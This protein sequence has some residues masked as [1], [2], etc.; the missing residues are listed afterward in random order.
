LLLDFGSFARRK[1]PAKSAHD[2]CHR[3]KIELPGLD[4]GV[5]QRRTVKSG[6]SKEVRGE[7]GAESGARSADP[8]LEA[9]HAVIDRTWAT[10]PEA[11]KCQIEQVFKAFVHQG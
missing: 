10:M 7:S 2:E 6:N 5:S 3:R 8:R 4:C 11:A 9:I 1:P